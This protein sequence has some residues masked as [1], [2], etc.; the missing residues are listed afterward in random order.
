MDCMGGASR[1]R[2]LESI[3]KGP[4]SPVTIQGGAELW[5]IT[6][7]LCQLIDDYE[8]VWSQTSHIH[9]NIAYV[10]GGIP[11][12]TDKRKYVNWRGRY[13]E[14][15]LDFNRT[16]A[17]DY[18]NSE[19]RNCEYRIKQKG[20]IPAFATVATMDLAAWNNHRN[21]NHKNSRKPRATDYLL[22]Q[23]EYPRMQI[24]LNQIV[25]DTNS[26]IRQ[27]NYENGVETLDLARYVMTPR[28]GC[29]PG[30]IKYKIRTGELK[31]VDG[32]HPTPALAAQ[33]N[34]HMSAVK[35]INRLQLSSPLSV[36]IVHDH[37]KNLCDY[38]GVPLNLSN[39]KYHLSDFRQ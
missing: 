37:S 22:F 32:C 34:F 17:Y 20:F 6:D 12:I 29:I 35:T 14:V 24:E 38:S 19:Y 9:P 13:E 18:L 11:D 21:T 30:E 39:F 2:A 5:K 3:F 1:A 33:W 7:N 26:M 36:K 25:M 23:S 27:I 4:L 28:E 31:F 15:V 8:P 16:H 10:V